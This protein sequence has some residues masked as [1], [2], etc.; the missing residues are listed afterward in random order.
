MRLS[1]PTQKSG[2]PDGLGSTVTTQVAI[3]ALGAGSGILS[4]RLLG[5]VGRGELAALVLW[6]SMLIFL[7]AMGIDQA[8]V[9]FTGKH[10]FGHSE[11]WTASIA[12]GLVQSLLVILVGMLIIPA[13]LQHYPSK[14]RDLSYLF[15]AFSPLVILCGYPG[16][17]FQGRMEL[18]RFNVLR[19]TPAVVYTGGLFLL[20]LTRRPLLEDVVAFQLLGY[21]MAFLGGCWLLHRCQLIRLRWNRTACQG[22]FAFG[23][24]TQLGNVSNFVNRSADQ[25]VLSLFVAPRELGLYAVAVTVA[26]GIGFLPQ[27]AGMVTLAS[28]SNADEAE[29]KRVVSRNFRI[30][31]VWLIVAC[32]TLFAIAGPL[33]RFAFG[34]AFSGSTLACRILLPGVVALGLNQV[35][36]DGARSFGH[37]ALPSYAEGAATAVTLVGLYL[38]LPRYGFAGAAIAS[39]CAYAGSFILMLF[40]TRTKLRLGV[41][42]LVGL[43]RG[44]PAR[45]SGQAAVDALPVGRTTE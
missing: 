45:Q 31:L 14:V 12:L 44:L 26:T 29:A 13:A 36:Y 37:P 4:A 15:L 17:I 35:L 11:I 21:A 18:T 38:L 8:I 20:L 34:P 1:T 33:I 30:S 19:T 43:A 28:G 40:L 25:L 22:I 10:S 16:D 41:W 39:T 27:A 2:L 42:E 24:K 3:L 5:P 32:A 7:A 23:F 6:P 9:F